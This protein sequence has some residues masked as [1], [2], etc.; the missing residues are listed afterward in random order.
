VFWWTLIWV[1]PHP[2]LKFID[3]LFV[4]LCVYRFRGLTPWNNSENKDSAFAHWLNWLPLCVPFVDIYS[5]RLF[6]TRFLQPDARFTSEFTR[7]RVL[8]YC[9]NSL[10]NIVLIFP[11]TQS[12]QLAISWLIFSTTCGLPHTFATHPGVVDFFRFFVKDCRTNFLNSS[13]LLWPTFS[14]TLG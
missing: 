8:Y 6:F 5:T 14:T 10:S 12:T 9:L 11:S 4:K 7:F 3:Q 2:S 13:A 1:P